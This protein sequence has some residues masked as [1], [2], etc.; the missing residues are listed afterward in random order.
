[1]DKVFL[2]VL[3]MSL[4]ASVVILCVMAVRLL[5]KRAPKI[6]SYALWAV[7]LFR[8]LCPVSLSSPVSLL[9]IFRPQVT[10]TAGVASNVS[11][12]PAVPASQQSGHTF[13]EAPGQGASQPSQAEPE[14]GDRPVS[15]LTIAGFV[16]L[17]GAAAM[18]AYSMAKYLRLRWKLVGAVHYRENTYLADHMESPFVLGILR[19]RV[20]LPSS[21]AVEERRY[22]IAHERHHIRRGDHIVK[23]LAYGALCVH[24]FNPLVWAAFL[25]AGKDME[26]SC[27]EAVIR[28]LGGHIRADYSASLLR[29]S[30]GFSSIS[31]TPLAFGEGD[32]KGRVLNMAKWKKPKLWVCIICA[33]VCIAVLVACAVNPKKSTEPEEALALP[34][35]RWNSSPEEVS[36]ALGL[37]MGTL[38]RQEVEPGVTT[39]TMNR[40]KIENGPTSEFFYVEVPDWTVFGETALTAMFC[41]ENYLPETSDYFGLSGVWIYYPEDCDKEA[42][43]TNLRQLYGPEAEEYTLN[44][45]DGVPLGITYKKEEGHFCWFSQQLVGD[46]LSEQGKQA[47]RETLGNVTD[48]SFEA[49]LALPVTRITWTEDF[50][51]QFEDLEYAEDLIAENGRVAWLGISGTIL[52]R[53]LQMYDTDIP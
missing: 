2:Q 35:I 26:M 21:T 18:V 3:N 37:Y 27:D 7:V 40:R 43:V 30:T 32:T 31:G 50:Y 19:P 23:L 10:E 39:F 16:W 1:M 22:I 53:M 15:V 42:I 25:L 8:L 29:L 33:V 48:Q 13:A 28:K 11:Y 34:G 4:T 45:V 46:I 51:S 38:N 9:E 52:S 6:F 47:Y 14:N 20:Y 17:A 5:L 12:F 41:F 49:C 24:W 44:S 36:E